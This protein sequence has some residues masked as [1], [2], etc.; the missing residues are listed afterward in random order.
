MRQL[1][2]GMFAR[3][4]AGHD[5]GRCYVVLGTK[6]DAVLL[7]DGVH[8]TIGSPKRK[9]RMHIQPDF[10]IDP[11][12]MVKWEPRLSVSDADIRA[13]VQRKEGIKDV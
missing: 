6:E 1:E 2:K 7:A 12:L 11:Q 10:H 8:Y 9:K 5:K 3:S 13:A 4:L